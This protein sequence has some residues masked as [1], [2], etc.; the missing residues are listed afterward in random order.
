MTIKEDANANANAFVETDDSKISSRVDAFGGAS[1]N[2]DRD[3]FPACFYCPIT[4][5]MVEDPVVAPDGTSY[6]RDAIVQR[7]GDAA[8]AKL[9]PNRALAQVIDER[10]DT[11]GD[12]LRAGFMRFQRSTRQSIR[13]L[14]EK[15]AIPSEEYRPLPD[16]YYCPIT[17]D[18]IHIPVIDPEGNTFEKAAILNWIRANG[19]SPITRSSVNAKDLYPNHAIAELLNQEKGKSEDSI[20]PSIRKW[21]AT[22][23]PPEEDTETG[24]GAGAGGGAAAAAA[25]N[26][27]TTP[28]ELEQR[29]R[30]RRTSALSCV[31]ICFALA[32]L[33][34]VL[35]YAPGA[36]FCA[37]FW[38]LC[39]FSKHRRRDSA[40]TRR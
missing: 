30:D 19:N 11:T 40:G 3:E 32:V 37:I 14:M 21:K 1:S 6:E 38:V 39:C 33:A 18:L 16:V 8:A 36:V 23:P 4:K 20:H 22:A 27:P 10:L 2:N 24:A 5:A 34:V 12:S 13:Q 17:F 15:S 29:R 31:G 9:Y 7:D 26:F 25:T 35:L 28:V